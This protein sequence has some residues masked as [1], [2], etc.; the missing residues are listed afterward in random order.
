MEELRSTEILEKEIQAESKKEAEK[1]LSAAKREAEK[2]LSET[3]P[4]L[5]SA[6]AEREKF[7]EEKVAK[8]EKVLQASVP[9]E[10]QRFLVSFVSQG[11]DS[12]LN[13]YFKKLSQE[14]RLEISLKP[15]SAKKE[16]FS[17]KKFRAKVYGFDLDLA[18]AS[19]EKNLKDNFL[20]A[21]KIDFALSGEEAQ[22]GIEFHEGVILESEDKGVKCRL[23]LEEAVGELKDKHYGELAEKL[24]GDEL[25]KI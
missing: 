12:A 5:E 10:S 3:E 25:R 20:S 7:Y 18:R 4:R 2:I 22:S 13:E 11:I 16:F 24:F 8:C 21:E 14:E 23:T 6:K 9:L 17:G 15:I 1:I 19:L